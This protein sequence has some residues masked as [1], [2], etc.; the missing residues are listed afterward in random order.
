MYLLH[1]LKRKLSFS[2]HKRDLQTEGHIEISSS[3]NLAQNIQYKLSR[4]SLL[5]IKDKASIAEGVQLTALN[6]GKIIIGKNVHIGRFVQINAMGGIVHIDDEVVCINDFTIITSWERVKIGSNTLIAPFCH[7]LDR[8]HGFRKN[9]LIRNQRGESYPII[10]GQDVWLGSGVIILKGV[11]IHD[12]AVVG[13][14]S[15]VISDIPA[16][17]V[18]VGNPARIIKYRE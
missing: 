11:K 18:A 12:G 1:Y 5:A 7:I 17:A 16:Y 2:T 3:A 14:G 9:D 6:G 10:I 15:V 4:D 8:D 13:A